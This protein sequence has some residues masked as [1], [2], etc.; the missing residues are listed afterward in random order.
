M[1]NLIFVFSLVLL[2][3]QISKA[4]F[5]SPS[6]Y[7]KIVENIHPPEDE[8]KDIAELKALVEKRTKEDS[9]WTCL[10]IADP[11]FS[12]CRSFSTPQR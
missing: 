5:L 6:D 3:Y 10:R 12:T 2:T 1:K 11:S 9:K 7:S 8:S 4:D